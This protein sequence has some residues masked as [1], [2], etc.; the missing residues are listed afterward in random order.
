[1]C[2]HIKD[3]ITLSKLCT[4][5]GDVVLCKM[6]ENFSGPH[7]HI[8]CCRCVADIFWQYS[9]GR[10]DQIFPIRVMFRLGKV[11]KTGKS[12]NNSRTR[13]AIYVYHDQILLRLDRENSTQYMSFIYIFYQFSAYSDN[14]LWWWLVQAELCSVIAGVHLKPT[15]DPLWVHLASLPEFVYSV[16]VSVGKDRFRY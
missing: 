9:H 1:V 6:Q 8:A 5:F 3:Y 14:V 12:N 11:K 7:A 13:S 4:S 2:T 10:Y 16:G 15:L